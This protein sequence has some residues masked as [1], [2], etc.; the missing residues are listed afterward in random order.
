MST[1]SIAAAS[2]LT[3]VTTAAFVIPGAW[4]LVAEM[5]EDQCDPEQILAAGLKWFDIVGELDQ[6]KDTTAGLVR[7]LGQD[8]WKGKD[9]DAFDGKMSDYENQILFEQI[10][11]GVVGAAMVILAV[12]L[13]ILIIVMVVIAVIMLW[14]LAIVLA[15]MAGIITSVATP[16]AIAT[17]SEVAVNCFNVL[18][19]VDKVE[20]KIALGLAALIGA[21]M[22]T[23]VVGEL[24]NGN[25]AVLGDLGN[26][27]IDSSD[28]ILWGTLSRIERDLNK[29]FMNSQKWPL[30][31]LGFSPTKFPRIAGVW[32]NTTTW[33]GDT[34]LSS[35]NITDTVSSHV[36]DFNR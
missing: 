8:E 15:T 16:A 14:Q 3:A 24:F 7:N 30:D 11:A 6:A 25:D 2:A 10:M 35:G 12:M 4:P 22:A 27:F 1:S 5:F 19:K 26:A 17:A 34:G 20:E 32:G 36:P 9:R 28:N 23:D 13:F 29:S 21:S 18:D 31:G 33:A